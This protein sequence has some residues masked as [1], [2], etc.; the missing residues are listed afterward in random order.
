MAA[1]NIRTETKIRTT[2]SG[3]VV[4]PEAAALIAEKMGIAKAVEGDTSTEV[5]K[6]GIVLTTRNA[7][8]ELVVEE[9]PQHE[10]DGLARLWEKAQTEGHS[11]QQ[12]ASLLNERER[13]IME[14][15]VPPELA[16]TL[17]KVEEEEEEAQPDVSTMTEADM[18]AAEDEPKRD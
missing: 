2:T 3:A 6:S 14:L 8:G 9:I 17:A 12:F 11:F 7:Q 1:K 4:S 13:S 10:A 15:Q 5:P 16:A 18:D